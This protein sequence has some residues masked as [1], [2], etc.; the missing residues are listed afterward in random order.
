MIPHL[1][2]FRSVLCLFSKLL[3]KIVN[4]VM[5]ESDDEDDEDDAESYAGEA[6]PGGGGGGAKKRPPTKSDASSK[7]RKHV[8]H[9]I[10]VSDL[11]NVLKSLEAQGLDSLETGWGDDEYD[12]HMYA[13]ANNNNMSTKSLGRPPNHPGRNTSQPDDDQH[14]VNRAVLAESKNVLYKIRDE[15]GMERPSATVSVS[16]E[17]EGGPVEPVLTE[18]EKEAMEAEQNR[19]LVKTGLKSAVAIG[20]HSQHGRRQR[21]ISQSLRLKTLTCILSPS[22]T[23]LSRGTRHLCGSTQ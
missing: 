16:S 18:K 20:K 19:R 3:H 9:G 11:G 15:H 17:E 4:Y 22:S 8:C 1:N 10:C 6:N 7:K 14:K 21:Q 12:A 5:K 13:C 2:S 23:Q